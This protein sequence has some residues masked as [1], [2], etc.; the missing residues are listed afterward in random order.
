MFPLAALVSSVVL[1]L[2][3]GVAARADQTGA[4]PVLTLSISGKGWGHGV[5]MGQWGA[6]GF[7]LRGVGYREILAHYY[8][9]TQLGKAGGTS[10]RVLLAEGASSVTVTS[11]GALT[12]QD[13][14]GGSY[15]L[16]AGSYSL[17]P[18]LRVQVDPNAPAK[19]LPGPIVLSGKGAPLQVN[20]RRYRGTLELAADKGKL[21]AVNIV[22]LEAYLL[23]VVPSEMP[24]TWPA[25]ALKAQA[26]A[27]RSYAL[28]TR[29]PNGP[30]DAY[31]DVRSQV[32]LGIDHEKPETTAAV[33]ATAGEVVLYQGRVA[34]TYFFSTSGGKTADIAEAWPGSPPVPYL[35]SVPDPHDSASPHHSW[36]PVAIGP[37]KLKNALGLPAVPVDARIKTSPSGRAAQVVFSLATGGETSVP[38]GKVRTALELR[39]TWFRIGVLSLRPPAK[40]P[41]VFGARARL[42]GVVRS[43]SPVTLE[44][45][46]AGS[47]WQKVARLALARDGSFALPFKGERTTDF[48]LVA[49]ALKTAPVRVPVAPNLRLR[50]VST[51]GLVEGTV[52]PAFPGATVGIQRLQGARWVA[53]GSAVVDDQGSFAATVA[54]LPGTYRARLAPRP[55]YAAALSQPLIVVLP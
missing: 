32:Y 31:A 7:A 19:A 14:A 38:A 10:M 17:G 3:G 28:A 34:V 8:R 40:L 2:G 27:A 47:A 33:Q 44:R 16:Q 23:G 50:P 49:T 54:E 25:E 52:R 22:G 46:Q 37:R 4:T 6:R 20:G 18:G 29:K 12:V 1:L 13:A 24:S 45:R 21:R 41:V 36:G 26:V 51:P 43:V 48:R 30:F 39:S 53:A 11:A 5:G 35:V 9:G 42:G 15:D 55:G